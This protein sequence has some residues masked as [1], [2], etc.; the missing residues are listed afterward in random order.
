MEVMMEVKEV[1]EVMLEVMMEVMD[2]MEE[3]TPAMDVV[4]NQQDPKDSDVIIIGG[5]MFQY[6]GNTF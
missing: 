6:C 1:K 3:V 4:T 5:G 2:I